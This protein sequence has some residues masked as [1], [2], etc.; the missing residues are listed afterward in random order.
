MTVKELIQELKA[1]DEKYQDAEVE[2][3]N[4]GTADCYRIQSVDEEP[5]FDAEDW[6]E[7]EYIYINI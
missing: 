4:T 6:D 3:C 7:C 2:I 5:S 1:I